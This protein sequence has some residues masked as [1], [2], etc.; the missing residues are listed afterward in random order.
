VRRLGP[1]GKYPGAHVGSLLGNVSAIAQRI[2][3]ALIEDDVVV[4]SGAGGPE[5]FFM[6]MRVAPDLPA[7]H[8]LG[9]ERMGASA[10]DIEEDLI[11]LRRS[12]V[13]GAMIV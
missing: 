8:L 3:M 9:T 13:S 11:E 4:W 7:E 12:R 2:Y 1:R 10:A 6:H 5:V